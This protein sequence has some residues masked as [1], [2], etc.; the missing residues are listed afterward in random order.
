MPITSKKR[1]RSKKWVNIAVTHDAFGCFRRKGEVI[2]LAPEDTAEANRGEG[3]SEDDGEYAR[4]LW[5]KITLLT[6]E[7]HDEDDHFIFIVAA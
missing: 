2:D 7:R 4:H 6:D 5:L 1:R 3:D